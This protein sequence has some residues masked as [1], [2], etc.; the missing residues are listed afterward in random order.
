MLGSLYH[1]VKDSARFAVGVR[2]FN[3]TMLDLTLA[4]ER[5][6]QSVERR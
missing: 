1:Y 4:G 2:A 6:F 3:K 5:R